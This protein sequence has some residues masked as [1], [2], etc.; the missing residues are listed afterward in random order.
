MDP[1]NIFYGEFDGRRS[2]A[3]RTKSTINVEAGKLVHS[4]AFLQNW[5]E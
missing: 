5:V 4:D 3:S 2:K 1:G